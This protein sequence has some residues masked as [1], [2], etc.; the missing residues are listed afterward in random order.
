MYIYI[1]EV[2]PLSDHEARLVK[3]LHAVDHDQDFVS[4]NAG[5]FGL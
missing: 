5:G 4:S 2:H 1:E 3:A